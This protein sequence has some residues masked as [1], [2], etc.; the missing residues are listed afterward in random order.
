MNQHP[1]SDAEVE[2]RLMA[3]AKA[4]PRLS[5]EEMRGIVL[6][7]TREECARL[8]RRRR[9][10]LLAAGSAACLLG[11]MVGLPL[12]VPERHQQ[13]E[14]EPLLLPELTPV[15]I[16]S[17]PASLNS[18]CRTVKM[19]SCHES[20]YGVD[21]EAPCVPV[22][23]V[24]V[25]QEVDEE[26][27]GADSLPEEADS[28]KNYSAD[29]FVL[30]EGEIP[31][32]IDPDGSYCY[33]KRPAEENERLR[34]A[35]EGCAV[36]KLT[37]NPRHRELEKSHSFSRSDAR[38][39]ALLQE[40]AAVPQWLD[41]RFNKYI[42]YEEMAELRLELLDTAGR[43]LWSGNAWELFYQRAPQTPPVTVLRKLRRLMPHRH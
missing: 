13:M 3:M 27:E 6:N 21:A 41:S 35:F 1:F 30:A 14:P 22:A 20:G 28:A 33:V 5:E 29:D 25:R 19:E 26:Y 39:A 15:A 10:T 7:A 17:S 36:M 31:V 18:G 23:V 9:R 16:Q 24:P 40:F 2:A 12:L 43:E 11:L 42:D 4:A 32:W 37:E 34:R 38:V 8:A